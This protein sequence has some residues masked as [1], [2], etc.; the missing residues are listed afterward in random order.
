M[1]A[2][3][4][5]EV[6]PLAN[7]ANSAAA[8]LLAFAVLSSRRAEA[9]GEPDWRAETASVLQQVS[10]QAFLSS[11]A[12]IFSNFLQGGQ[13]PITAPATL[14]VPSNVGHWRYLARWTALSP[15]HQR[16]LLRYH[17]LPSRYTAQQ[18]LD[19]PPLTLFPTFNHR[20]PLNKTLK[21]E[22]VYFQ[23]VP[24]MKSASPL[25]VPDAGL[26]TG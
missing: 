25:S 1:A 10:Q 20:L 6:S 23:S 13:Q 21:P 26:R 19:A 7:L 2:R 16:R 8:L 15:T 9:Q 14:L 11:F 18:L 12:A 5:D 24:P 3:Q 17:I 22:E 4:R